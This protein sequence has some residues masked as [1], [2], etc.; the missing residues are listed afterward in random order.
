MIPKSLE[1]KNLTVDIH[2]API[3]KSVT[4]EVYCHEILSIIGAAG[5]GKTTL[6]RVINRLSDLNQDLR[7]QGNV[8]F[9]DQSIFDKRLDLS[10]IRRKMGLVFSVPTPLPLSIYDNIAFGIR[11]ID[12]HMNKNFLSHRVEESLT[13]AYLWNEVKDR[14]DES[15]LKLSGGQQQRLCLARTLALKPEVLLL[16][17]PCSGLDPISTAQIEEAL[18]EL[19]KNMAIVLVTNNI[20]QASRVSDRT[21]FL[22]TGE[23]IEIGPTQELFTNP[24]DSRTEDYITGRF[25]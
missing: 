14:L 23:L 20:K 16:D 15:A 17:E 5:S 2:G 12:P 8:M 7:V 25:G 3:L 19:K 18:S 6:L 13:S 9:N 22:L 1:I 21:A 10:E 4:F 11:L 24:K